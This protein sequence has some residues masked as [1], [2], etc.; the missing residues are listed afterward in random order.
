M[1]ARGLYKGEFC[2]GDF[3]VASTTHGKQRTNIY[4]R[5]VYLSDI[6]HRSMTVMVRSSQTTSITRSGF[7]LTHGAYTKY[8]TALSRFLS[9]YC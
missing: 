9:Q 5:M 2:R 7:A 1:I 6:K 4:F 8:W 3:V